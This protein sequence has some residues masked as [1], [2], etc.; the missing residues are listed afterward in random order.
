MS[1][2]PGNGIYRANGNGAFRSNQLGE[3]VVLLIGQDTDALRSLITQLAEK[4]AHIALI[5]H[6]FSASNSRHLQDLVES[7]GRRF[8]FIDDSLKETGN[9]QEV[10]SEIIQQL[11][12]LD[13]LIDLSASIPKAKLNGSTPRKSL[14]NRWMK[15]DLLDAVSHSS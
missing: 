13:I 7:A 3:K 15:Q 11:G 8:L 4:G 1:N 6:N 9:A 2:N 12:R 14:Y 5:G 10:V